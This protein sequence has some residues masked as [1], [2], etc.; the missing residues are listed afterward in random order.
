MEAQEGM[1]E[2]Q[3]NMITGPWFRWF[4][5]YDPRP[6]L[7]K[8]K[9]PVLAITGEKDLQVDPDQ[10][11]PEIEKALTAGNH[12]NFVVKELPGLN[13]L[14]QT[15]ST[16]SIAEYGQIEETISPVALEEIGTWIVKQTSP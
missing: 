13:H 7:A 14:F 16:G 10:N 6:T 3:T 5:T 11:L 8:V 15:C 12:G 1:L 2:M 4:L 9:C